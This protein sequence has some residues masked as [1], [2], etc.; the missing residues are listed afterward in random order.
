MEVA[1]FA[2]RLR[3]ADPRCRC[4]GDE[5]LSRPRGDELLDVLGPAPLRNEHEQHTAIGA[6]KEIPFHVCLE[7]NLPSRFDGGMHVLE[8]RP[9]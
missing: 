5:H 9:Q 6:D 4:V 2:A 8:G 7:S 3:P 1:G